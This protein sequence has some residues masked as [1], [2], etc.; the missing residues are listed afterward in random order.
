MNEAT[1]QEWHKFLLQKMSEGLFLKMFP[2]YQNSGR[3]G[4]A[5]ETQYDL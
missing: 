5:K 4:L 1:V 2:N 3:C